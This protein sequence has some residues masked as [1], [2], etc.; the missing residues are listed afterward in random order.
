[1]NSLII[2]VLIFIIAIHLVIKMVLNE[3]ILRYDSEDSENETILSQTKQELSNYIQKYLNNNQVK[4][5]NYYQDFTKNNNSNLLGQNTDLSKY[6]NNA[7]PDA[8]FQIKNNN[9]DY[10]FGEPDI[11]YKHLKNVPLDKMTNSS[12]NYTIGSGGD[13]VMTKDLWLYEDENVMN[14]G[15]FGGNVLPND[16]EI[17]NYMAI[18]N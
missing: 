13:A 17:D 2:S 16:L 15:S 14:G 9:T 6:F 10:S 12:T 7:N 1:M 8:R 11:P 18:V 3:T 5:S 4:E